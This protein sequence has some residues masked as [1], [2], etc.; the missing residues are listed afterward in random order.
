MLSLGKPCLCFCVV[1]HAVVLHAQGHVVRLREDG[2]HA[3]NK[4]SYATDA[5][6]AELYEN[7]RTRGAAPHD[8]HDPRSGLSA[9]L[10]V[11]A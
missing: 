10:V 3:G 2:I 11:V 1:S 5:Q 8:T 4:K 9:K 7:N 6:Q